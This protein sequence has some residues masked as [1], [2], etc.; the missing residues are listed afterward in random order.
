MA[1]L[2]LAIL[3]DSYVT[4]NH[5]TDRLTMLCL[6]LHR[7]LRLLTVPKRDSDVSG[8]LSNASSSL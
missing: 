5:A 3:R 2:Q 1:S 6:G 8:G 7:I 4:A